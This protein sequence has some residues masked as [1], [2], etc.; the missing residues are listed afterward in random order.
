MLLWSV[1]SDVQTDPAFHNT[2]EPRHEKTC[3]C[4]MQTTKA[5]ISLRM[6][7]VWSAPLLF[8]A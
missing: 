3:L 2:Y 5:Q 7:T 1:D 4:K 6:R 8:T